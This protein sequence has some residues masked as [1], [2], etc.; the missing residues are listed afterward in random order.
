MPNDVRA[1]LLDAMENLTLSYLRKWRGL[2]AVMGPS[3][4]PMRGDGALGDAYHRATLTD[5]QLWVLDC[6][7]VLR[8]LDVVHRHAAAI[9]VGTLLDGMRYDEIARET[10]VERCAVRG[11]AETAAVLF[12]TLVCS[13]DNRGELRLPLSVR[14][15]AAPRECA[16]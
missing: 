10:G 16:A 7:T 4:I 3:A 6:E 2:R 12:A 5:A 11:I 13:R 14:V 1:D 15:H 9:L 8:D